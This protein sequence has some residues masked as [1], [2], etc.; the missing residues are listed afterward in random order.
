M[1]NNFITTFISN[2]DDIP[3]EIRIMIDHIKSAISAIHNDQKLPINMSNNSKFCLL[4]PK[5]CDGLK[6][7]LGAQQSNFNVDQV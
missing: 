3:E 4:T 5:V 1:F 2:Q 7:N 6:D